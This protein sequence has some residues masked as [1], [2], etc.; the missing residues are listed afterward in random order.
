MNDERRVSAKMPQ[1]RLLSRSS[2]GASLSPLLVIT[3]VATLIVGGI[4]GVFKK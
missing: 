3:D 2:V 4:T 1:R